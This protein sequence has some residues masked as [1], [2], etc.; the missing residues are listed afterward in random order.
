M[1]RSISVEQILEVYLRSSQDF[2]HA[3]SNLVHT[4]AHAKELMYTLTILYQLLLQH[5]IELDI[6]IYYI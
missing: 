3:A 1:A 5:V 6:Y 4:H 2:Q